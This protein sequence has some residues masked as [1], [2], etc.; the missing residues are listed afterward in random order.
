MKTGKIQIGHTTEDKGGLVLSHIHP[1]EK[2]Q[3]I[4]QLLL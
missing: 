1:K 3:S 2:Q 4:E